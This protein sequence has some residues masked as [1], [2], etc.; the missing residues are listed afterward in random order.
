MNSQKEVRINVF[1]LKASKRLTKKGCRLWKGCRVKGYGQLRGFDN[2]P[3]LA[4]RFSY[5]LHYGGFDKKLC[6]CHKCDNPSCVNPEHL[7]LGTHSDNMGDRR[8]KNEMKRLALR[9]VSVNNND[10]GNIEETD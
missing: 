10:T 3:T 1:N 4:H 2:K 5:E 7:F 8:I 9:S 6:V